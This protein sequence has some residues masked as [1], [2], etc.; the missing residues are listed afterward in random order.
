[1]SPIEKPEPLLRVDGLTKRFGGI[2]ASDSISLDVRAGEIHA[3]IGPNGAGKTTLIGLLC[4]ELR[5][6]AGHVYFAGREITALSVSRR[7]RLGLVR[8]FQIPS[9]LPNL[10][11]TENVALAV[12]TTLGHGYH[13]WADAGRDEALLQPAR[14]AIAE[15]ALDGRSNVVAAALSHGEQ[16]QLELAMVLAAKPRLLLLDEPL[17]GMGAEESAFVATLLGRLKGRIGMLLVE[18]DMEAVFALADRI[19]VLVYGRVIAVG[20]AASI[21]ANPEVQHAYLGEEHA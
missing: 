15:L 18:H 20:D 3:V 19:T 16:R 14:A 2:T 5:P 9:I 21:R 8:S 1:M 4:G 10:T 7:A 17:A 6:A 13:F 11:V 12:Q